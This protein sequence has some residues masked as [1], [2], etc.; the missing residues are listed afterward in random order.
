LQHAPFGV[1]GD[2]SS[3]Q[4]QV[5]DAVG[6]SDIAER[7]NVWMLVDFLDLTLIV[8]VRERVSARAA[9]RIDDDGEVELAVA[10]RPA[11]G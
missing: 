7:A 2:L 3:Q 8:L 1:G 10:A 5:L 9:V 11:D 4:L 6:G